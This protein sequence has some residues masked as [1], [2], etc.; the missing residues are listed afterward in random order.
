MSN[1][2]QGV[3]TPADW[4]VTAGN[5]E[6]VTKNADGTIH[7]PPG[8]AIRHRGLRDAP[9]RYDWDAMLSAHEMIDEHDQRILDNGQIPDLDQYK[10]IVLW[11][12]YFDVSRKQ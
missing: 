8:Y 11:W 1:T 5:A 6:R 10:R 9:T 4:P 2:V 3:P 7:F 12:D